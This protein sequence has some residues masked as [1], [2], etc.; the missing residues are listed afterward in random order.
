MQC[1]RSRL[2]ERSS[3]P[4]GERDF[5]LGSHVQT[6]SKSH[7][8][9]Y[10][11]GTGNFIQRGKAAGVKL[12]HIHLVSKSRKEWRYT[13]APTRLHDVLFSLSPGKNVIFLSYMTTS[14]INYK[15]YERNSFWVFIGSLLYH[16][17]NGENEIT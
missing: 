8:G 16:H 6:G 5:S 3:V 10:P 2:Y 7:P 12:I 9:S 11:M 1:L 4:A 13:C 17:L 14:L 15:L